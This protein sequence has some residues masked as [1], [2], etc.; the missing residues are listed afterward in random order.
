MPL[1]RRIHS[2][3]QLRLGLILLLGYIFWFTVIVQILATSPN[4]R[5]SPPN[6]WVVPNDR[7]SR[8]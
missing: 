7:N 4:I 1:E 3:L 2:D 8:E 6:P 5:K